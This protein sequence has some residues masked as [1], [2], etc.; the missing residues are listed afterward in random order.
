[1]PWFTN[2]MQIPNHRLMKLAG[3]SLANLIKKYYVNSLFTYNILGMTNLFCSKLSMSLSYINRCFLSSAVLSDYFLIHLH[4]PGVHIPEI[5]Y[6]HWGT[7]THTTL[8]HL[9]A[10]GLLAFPPWFWWFI[11]RKKKG[12]RKRK[13]RRIQGVWAEIRTEIHSLQT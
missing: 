3:T 12:K 5:L 8:L 1:M 2:S 10:F 9:L 6:K 7:H 11:L 4:L 13:G